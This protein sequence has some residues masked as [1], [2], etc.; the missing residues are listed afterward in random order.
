VAAAVPP[1]TP[2]AS[3]GRPRWLACRAPCRCALHDQ[4]RAARPNGPTA[5]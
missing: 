5:R 4:V 1:V 2:S 3:A